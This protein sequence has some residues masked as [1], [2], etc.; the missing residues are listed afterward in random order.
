MLFELSTL[1]KKK[2]NIMLRAKDFNPQE[3]YLYDQ[4]LF[5]TCC[6][7]T[8]IFCNEIVTISVVFTL[9]IFSCDACVPSLRHTFFQPIINKSPLWIEFN[10][11]QT[12]NLPPLP[13]KPLRINSN[14]KP[15]T[16]PTKNS[17]Q[18]LIIRVA[19]AISSQLFEE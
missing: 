10:H 7:H 19:C 14:C 4:C 17:R 2:K 12:K 16:S 6:T 18:N 8:H 5:Y 13:S 9:F 1:T 11:A 3:R 15:R